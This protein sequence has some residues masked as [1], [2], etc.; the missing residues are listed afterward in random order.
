MIGLGSM[1]KPTFELNDGLEQS[2]SN[3]DQDQPII[4]KFTDN[5]P[6]K[7]AMVSK[8]QTLPLLSSTPPIVSK[9]LIK[10]YPYLIIVNKILSILTWTNED[11]WVNMVILLTTSIFILYFENLITY[12]GHIILLM[13]ITFYALINNRILQSS[14]TVNPTLDEI[15]QQ[16]T[17]T[18]INSDILLSPITNLSLTAM[19]I[20]RLLFTTIFLTP[21]Y[22]IGTIFIIKPRIILLITF[23]YVFSYNSSYS[24]V[25][26]RLI[27]KIK[28]TRIICFYLTGLNFNQTKNNS[29][30]QAALA[31]VNNT[32]NNNSLDSSKP[33]RFTYVIYENQRRWLGIGWTSNL[34][35]YERAP[36]TDEFL[37]ESDN[38]E[39]FQL[40][41]IEDTHIQLGT[42]WQWVDKSWRLDLTND[43]AISLTNSK[44]GKT[45]ANPD[46]DEG[47]IY[48]DN[49]W[50]KP[51]TED[52]FS[53]YT[54]RRRWIRTAE[55]VNSK[56]Q[57]VDLSK[58]K[59]ESS[60]IE[61]KNKSND[62]T[63]KKRRVL[64]FEQDLPKKVVVEISESK[65][66]ESS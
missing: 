49:T 43:G 28:L 55:L 7:S 24:R 63:I 8:P 66:E 48:Y 57:S 26:R 39:N 5:R 62:E 34:L 59:L 23:I 16:L 9:A 53:K 13:S 27:W 3:L 12:V 51:S 64:R 2:G 1:S 35:S 45:T 18:C 42:N 6:L 52:S 60:S 30:F 33:V 36:W 54:R 10:A 47:F 56:N 14:Q 20:K 4:A 61:D 31:K 29:L 11:Y 38:I 41:K 37:N 21:L 25:L 15:I 50:R 19:D 44:R 40:P 58:N 17:T 46:S 32:T 22:L 65:P